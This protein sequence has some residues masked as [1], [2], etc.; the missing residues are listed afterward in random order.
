[1]AFSNS[2]KRN[3]DIIVPTLGAGGLLYHFIKKG[4]DEKKAVIYA[5]IG[6]VL[7]YII[8]TRITKSLR[9]S[10]N[11]PDEV[12]RVNPWEEAGKHTPADSFDPI[13][14]SDRL[15][16]DL[17]GNKFSFFGVNEDTELYRTIELMSNDQLIQ[18]ANQFNLDYYSELRKTIVGA[19]ESEDFSNM[20]T[21]TADRVK[22]IIKR[23][24]NLKFN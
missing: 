5:V 15:Y 23:L 3:I 24:R 9:L 13:Y 2:N 14:W 10:L 21:G 1:M 18:I 20:F 16:Q 7:L 22:S 12:E 8:T 17:K 11:K 19:L 6:F 4:E